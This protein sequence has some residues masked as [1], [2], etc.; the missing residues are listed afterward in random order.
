MDGSP[1]TDAPWHPYYPMNAE[2]PHYTANETP[3]PKL[4][5]TFAATIASVVVVTVMVARRIHP[6]MIT[7]DQLI[8]AWFALCYFIW[9]HRR[10]AGMQTLFAQLWKEYALSDSRYLTSDPFMLCVESFTVVVWGPLCWAIVITIAQRNYARYPLQIIM[11]VGHLYGVVLYYSTSL[12][13]FY[14]N[15]VS[16]SRPDFLYFWVY[17]VG[18][19]APWVAVPAI[20]L[21]QSVVHIKNGLE[22]RHVKAT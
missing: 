16:H 21:F 14:F 5:V 3:L 8:V 12:T 4:L 20:L 9:N 19:N 17:Y 2:L 1:G 15:G 13:E 6:N 11:C 10:L 22:S 7:S 18:F